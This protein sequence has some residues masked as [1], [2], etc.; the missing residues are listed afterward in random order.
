MPEIEPPF[1]MLVYVVPSKLV[2]NAALVFVGVSAF[3]DTR[4]EPHVPTDVSKSALLMRVPELLNPPKTRATK[5]C[6]CGIDEAVAVVSVIR[7]CT[8]MPDRD[9]P[10]VRFGIVPPLATV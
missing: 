2:A 6:T 8:E 7:N 4:V 1:E 10:A 5:Y 9:C 3:Q